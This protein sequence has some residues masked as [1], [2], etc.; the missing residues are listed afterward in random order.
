[1][2][3]SWAPAPHW[4]YEQ[5]EQKNKQLRVN[6][7]ESISHCPRGLCAGPLLGQICLVVRGQ[8]HRRQDTVAGAYVLSVLNRTVCRLI[9][10]RRMLGCDRGG[11]GQIRVEALD[12]GSQVVHSAVAAIHVVCGWGGGDGSTRAIHLEL[13]AAHL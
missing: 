11:C 2:P 6:Y 8:I 1:M 5:H 7:G 12:R 4:D 3:T 9:V 10:V 13:R